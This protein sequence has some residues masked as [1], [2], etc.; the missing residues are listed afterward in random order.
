MMDKLAEGL[1]GTRFRGSAFHWVT[2]IGGHDPTVVER[3]WDL[4][5]LY[6]AYY[7]LRIKD[8]MESV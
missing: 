1:K 8:L 7:D 5:Q 3:D 2:T 6:D 4:V